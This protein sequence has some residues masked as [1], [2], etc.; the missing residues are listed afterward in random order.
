V[1]SGNTN[2]VVV[3]G[4]T[5]TYETA[6][7]SQIVSVTPTILVIE[8]T[9][10]GTY[11]IM[12]YASYKDL[13]DN[14]YYQTYTVP[15]RLD[16][17]SPTQTTTITI[18][19]TRVKQ[20]SVRPGDILE[21]DVVISCSGANSYD[22]LSVLGLT[23]TSP[24]S[25][26][27]PTTMSLGDIEE[28]GEVTTTYTLLVDGDTSAGQY[29]VTLT[30]SYT[31]SV[32]AVRTLT[33]TITI[34]VEGLI[35]FKLLDV[36]STT[37]Y[38][39]ETAELDADILLIG[40]ESVQFVSIEVID[41]QVFDSVQGSTEYI[42]AVDPDSPIPFD[43]KY[44]VT[45]DTEEGEYDLELLVTYRDHLNKPHEVKLETGIEINAQN[46]VME[47]KKNGGFWSWLRNLFS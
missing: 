13:E 32:G 42:G 1:S 31:D 2:L 44:C 45:D 34:M 9:A 24:L 15:L 17:T 26:V 39:G 23:T 47:E 27:T 7:T 19:D 22:A 40:T 41:N 37:V 4:L 12:V 5:M 11:S 8:G 30:V 36:P 29:P 33:E 25:P 35:E 14:S 38:R 46:T 10:I 43:V 3:N 6:N 20:T 28:D 18:Q 16:E 21:L